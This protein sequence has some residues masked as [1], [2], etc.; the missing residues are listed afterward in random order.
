MAESEQN[1]RDGRGDADRDRQQRVACAHT[2]PRQR[3]S[4]HEGITECDD[5]ICCCEAEPRWRV[6]AEELGREV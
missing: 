3:A 6:V 1:K 2:S 4:I 5:P